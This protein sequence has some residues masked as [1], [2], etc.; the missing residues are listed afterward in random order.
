ML[1]EKACGK[2]LH[3]VIIQCTLSIPAPVSAPGRWL[4]AAI[5]TS[6][7]V[8]ICVTNGC[9]WLF[10]E[11]KSH[12]SINGSNP[13]SP[14]LYTVGLWTANFPVIFPQRW[15]WCINVSAR[16]PGKSK[17]SVEA[18]YFTCYGKP[19]KYFRNLL[20]LQWMKPIKQQPRSQRTA[21][22]NTSFHQAAFWSTCTPFAHQSSR[23]TGYV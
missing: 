23:L 8:K 1:K 16:F 9:S 19:S 14:T 6:F 20:V 7:T 4:T 12:S 21:S 11:K 5:T 2:L 18:Q 17:N 3:Q 13:L 15:N 10:L 22:R